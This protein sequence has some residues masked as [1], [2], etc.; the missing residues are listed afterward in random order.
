VVAATH[1]SY[2]AWRGAGQLRR[3]ADW[4]AA[5]GEPAVLLGD[6]NLPHRALRPTLSGTGWIPADPAGATYPA[7]RPRVQLDHVLVRGA[8]VRC[9]RV[10]PRATSDHLPVTAEVILP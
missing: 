7:W 10:L 1:L 5:Q 2:L 8:R 3:A 9:A 4:V 6:L